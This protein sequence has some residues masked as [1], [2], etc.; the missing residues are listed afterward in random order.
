VLLARRFAAEIG[1]RLGVGEKALSQDA[2]VK[3]RSCLWPGNVRQ[4][5]NAIERAVVVSRDRGTLEARDLALDVS[6]AAAGNGMANI[7]I[8]E[9]GIC[10]DSVVHQLEK[11]L[12][13]K[14]L[15]R[16][17]GNKKQAA[18]LLQL[19]RTTLIEKLKRLDPPARAS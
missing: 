12:I 8:P 6:A 10:F 4:L 13:L 11:Q 15:E 2:E 17:G 1:L 19:K 9:D 5:Q 18:E 16:S 14:S 7:S 3:I